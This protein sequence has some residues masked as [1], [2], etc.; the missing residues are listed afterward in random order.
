MTGTS[1]TGSIDTKG[2][3][4][5]AYTLKGHVSEGDKARENADC[6]AP[7]VV[8]AFEPPTVSCSASPVT[9][10][11]GDPSTITA[12]GS[13]PQ[14]RP[15]TYAY[16]SDTGAM[17]GSGTTAVLSTSGVAPGPV[18]VT[19]NVEDDKGQTA[20]ATTSVTVT[21]PAVAPKPSTSDLCTIHFDRDLSRP[22]R[23]DNE[24]KACLDEVA[25]SLQRNS[26]AK[27]AL[28]GNAASNEKA[29]KKLATARAANTK[30]YLVGEKGIDSSR[31]AVYTGSQDGKTVSTTLIPAGATLDVGSDTPV[32]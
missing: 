31:I 23:V 12:I 7:F 2:V 21:A 8:K 30:A 13:S 32:D 5:G 14:N 24:A 28:I 9:V 3:S 26:D 15:L 27:L 20:S 4:A 22:V 17:S 11:S 29:G 25:L 6:T 1:S 18:A 16:H 10:V 19:C